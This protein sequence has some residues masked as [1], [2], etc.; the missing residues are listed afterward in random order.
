MQKI[1][2]ELYN[3]SMQKRYEKMSD[4]TTMFTDDEKIIA[5]NI[6]KE[7]EWMARNKSGSLNIYTRKPIK[8]KRAWTVN[9]ID[10]YDSFAGFKYM[11]SSVKWE[12]DEPTLIED[13]YNPRILNDT[14]REYLKGL[15]RPFHDRIAWVVKVNDWCD[16]GFI[17][18]GINDG[19]TY[20]FP[21]FKKG[22]KYV[23]MKSGHP[24]SL[25]ELGITYTDDE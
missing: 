3:D 22:E 23:G 4:N 25:R 9:R 1:K 5:R 8:G 6:D 20:R 24:Y 15:L 10:E 11:F 21:Y 13:I 18:V 16:M 17:G 2:C 7:Y 12:D 19:D 14:E